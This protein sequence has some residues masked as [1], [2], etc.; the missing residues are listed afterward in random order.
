MCTKDI[1]S[2]LLS[3]SLPKIGEVA[4]D[5]KRGQKRFFEVNRIQP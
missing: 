1:I 3:E 5:P 4:S 2:Y